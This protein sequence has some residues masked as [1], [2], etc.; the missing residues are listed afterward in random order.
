MDATHFSG[1]Y[2]I[3]SA[4]TAGG[5]LPTSSSHR[6]KDFLSSSSSTEELEQHVDVLL[7][8]QDVCQCQSRITDRRHGACCRAPQMQALRCR[9]F[10]IDID[11][12]INIK[13]LKPFKNS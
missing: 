13:V 3:G 10:N 12:I 6:E 5:K 4:R 7:L 2:T 8:D 9:R 11:S 1:H